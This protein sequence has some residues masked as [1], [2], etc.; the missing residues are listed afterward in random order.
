MYRWLSALTFAAT[1]VGLL[2]LLINADLAQRPPTQAELEEARIFNTDDAE[3]FGEDPD[4]GIAVSLLA[5]GEDSEG[6]IATLEVN[7]RQQTARVGE[8]LL[9]PCVS[10]AAMLDDGV[11]LDLCGGYD[12]LKLSID[13]K[14]LTLPKKL[15][16]SGRE[17]SPSI[18]DLR[19]DASLR[20]LLRDYRSRLFNRPLS[21][22]GQIEVDIKQAENGRRRFFVF[23]GKDRR[24]FADLPLQA[25]DQ[26][27]AVNGT[28]LA[29]RESI[30]D[31]YQNL[32]EAQQLTVTLVRNQQD[33]VLLL[34]L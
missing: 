32:E 28:P 34:A 23:P 2:V 30:S 14:V 9:P 22:V 5:L 12:L 20:A 7:G 1:L 11:L 21:L 31:I 29:A 16:L 6:G 17:A 19:G 18:I 15:A 13:A 26:V 4:L 24:L 33:L 25:G 3:W 10:L 27:L 8:T